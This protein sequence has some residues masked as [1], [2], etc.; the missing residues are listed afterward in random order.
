MLRVAQPLLCSLCSLHDTRVALVVCD[1]RM[2][3]AAPCILDRLAHLCCLHFF[4][5]VGNC[6]SLLNALVLGSQLA[7]LLVCELFLPA[8]ACM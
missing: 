8:P 2:T 4:Y 5:V 3:I 1:M 6:L 7:C